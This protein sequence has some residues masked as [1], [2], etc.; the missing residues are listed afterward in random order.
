MARTFPEPPTRRQ[1]RPATRN[2][3]PPAT[4]PRPAVVTKE[5]GEEVGGGRRGL[6]WFAQ[7][8]FHPCDPLHVAHRP[9][10]VRPDLRSRDAAAPHPADAL[11]H[12]FALEVGRGLRVT[13]ATHYCPRS[14]RTRFPT[15]ARSAARTRARI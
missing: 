11:K 6:R 1:D 12:Q 9:P 2:H 14:R 15:R 5:R 3:I 10:E 7:A 13:P 8:E 4:L